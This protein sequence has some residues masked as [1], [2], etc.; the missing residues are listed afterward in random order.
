MAPWIVAG[1]ARAVARR[2]GWR[3]MTDIVDAVTRS[4]MMAGIRGKDTGPN[5]AEAGPARRVP[6]PAA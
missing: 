5:C 4:R 1:E 6:F 2:S 3:S